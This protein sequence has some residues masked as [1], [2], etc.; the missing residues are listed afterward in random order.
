MIEN[1]TNYCEKWEKEMSDSDLV[2]FSINLWVFNGIKFSG[3]WVRK[4]IHGK[5]VE[6]LTKSYIFF[7]QFLIKINNVFKHF[8]LFMQGTLEECKTLSLSLSLVSE[9]FMIEEGS[10]CICL[11]V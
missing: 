2:K 9:T 10:P 5:Y 3:R 6:H 7:F 11:Q 8:Q 4:I 1:T